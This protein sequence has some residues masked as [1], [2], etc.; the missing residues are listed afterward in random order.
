MP[1]ARSRHHL[2]SS[3][4]DTTLVADHTAPRLGFIRPSMLPPIAAVLGFVLGTL[5]WA[6]WP[7]AITSNVEPAGRASTHVA[8]APTTSISTRPVTAL[9][10]PAAVPIPDG[11]VGRPA[12]AVAAELQAL[13]LDHRRWNVCS[14]SVGLGEVRQIVDDDEVVL[15]DT[16]GVREAGEA[17]ALGTQVTLKV[18]NGESCP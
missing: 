15:A 3:P 17:V 4:S 9:P 12:G 5:M 6:D 16:D 11:L 10:R 18:G 14:S 8:A 7:N 2:P 1:P 13:G